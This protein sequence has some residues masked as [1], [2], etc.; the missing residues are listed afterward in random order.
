[1]DTYARMSYMSR[2]YR[3]RTDCFSHV[4]EIDEICTL[5]YDPVFVISVY[6]HFVKHFDLSGTADRTFRTHRLDE[7][8]LK[9]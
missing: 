2:L 3:R 6:T 7:N 5:L 9:F 4:F 8:L 1:M